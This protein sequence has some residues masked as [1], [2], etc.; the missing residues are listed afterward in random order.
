[1]IPEK[2]LY[3]D[4]HEVTVTESVFKVKKTMYN[5]KG[6]TKHGFLIIQ[7]HRLVPL[8]LALGGVAMISTGTLHLVPGNFVPN[9]KFHA[10]A[11]SANAIAL[12]LGVMLLIASSIVLSQLKEKYAIR[13]ATAEGE[14][15]VL[16]SKRKEYI[17]QIID[18]L[19]KAFL[20]LVSPKQEKVK[21]SQ[22]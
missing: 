19:N 2:I 14:K 10:V 12:G 11:F 7:P 3:T 9:I 15:N 6:I 20:N 1:M 18:A 16:V 5:L 13:I 21:G 17:T 22:K 4:G 8:L